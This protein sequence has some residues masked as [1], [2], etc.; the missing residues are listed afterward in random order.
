MA[1]VSTKT[2]LVI[3]KE[4]TSHLAF[5]N[6]A[7]AEI[8]NCIDKM[9]GEILNESTGEILELADIK[10]AFQIIDT[11]ID[12]DAHWIKTDDWDVEGENEEDYEPDYDECGFDPY[13]GCYSYDC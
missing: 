1:T 3:S 12:L 4:E 7:L 10:R 8:A 6:L 11:L 2:S 9:G 13:M 5:A